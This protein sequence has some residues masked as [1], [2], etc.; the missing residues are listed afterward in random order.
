MS[1]CG[2]AEAEELTRSETAKPSL[3]GPDDQ[4]GFVVE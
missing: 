4:P 2:P 1:W 3:S